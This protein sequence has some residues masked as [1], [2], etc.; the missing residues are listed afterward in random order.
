M[1]NP[2][3]SSILDEQLAV[4]G[5]EINFWNFV[6]PAV[7]TIGSAVI[8]SSASRSASRS[9][10]KAQEDNAQRQYDYDLEKYE[11]QRKG[12]IAEREES[13]QRIDVARRNE[14]RVADFKDANAQQSYNYSMQ[15]RNYQQDSMNRQYMKSEDLFAEQLSYNARSA[16]AA[17]ET[18]LRALSEE[19][20]KFAFE[21]ENQIIQ[22]LVREGQ[23][24]ARG[25]T[26]RS[27]QKVG[28][29][30]LAA[31]GRNQAVMAES[32]VSA[33]RNTKA[34]LR[35]I[36][37]QHFAADMGAYARRMLNPGELPEPVKPFAT[38]LAEYMYPRELQD[39]DFGPE[40]IKGAVSTYT[41]SWTSAFAQYLPGIAQSAQPLLNQMFTPTPQSTPLSFTNVGSS[42]S[43]PSAATPISNIPRTGY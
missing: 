15:I 41:P 14:K 9:A 3:G 2:K 30:Q 43:I 34:Q 24:R 21:N 18:Q 40:P 13:I 8:G 7:A 11:L 5:L 16:A 33:K 36:Q 20:Q 12:L 32:M 38:P 19:A 29:A 26:G 35:E 37:R 23:F 1:F 42:F 31:L 6:I 10:Q 28:Q 27:A 22:S 17:K 39:Y 4:S 25:M